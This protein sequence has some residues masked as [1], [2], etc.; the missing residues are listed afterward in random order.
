ME[1]FKSVLAEILD[2]MLMQAKHTKSKKPTYEGLPDRNNI[3]TKKIALLLPKGKEKRL[4]QYEN[5]VRNG[6]KGNSGA[7]ISKDTFKRIAQSM[8]NQEDEKR[9]YSTDKMNKLINRVV[10]GNSVEVK[11]PTSTHFFTRGEGGFSKGKSSLT[12]EDVSARAIS[13]PSTA[14][15]SVK[16]DPKT[17]IASV[18]FTK[19]KKWYDYVMNPSQF[20]DF[21]NASSKGRYVNEVM[22]YNNLL[23]G[24]VS[25][26]K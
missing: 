25:P 10:K 11:A 19:G 7:G 20:E 6:F 3:D 13:K 16:F 21:M 12:N 22:H 26:R 18:L 8:L 9:F 1:D 5:K 2:S 23:P 4:E 15:Q 24:Y 17:G 14:I